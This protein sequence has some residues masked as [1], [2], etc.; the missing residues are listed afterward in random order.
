M[1]DA[2]PVAASIAAYS[3]DPEGYERAYAERS[4]DIVDR[5]SSL[6]PGGSTIL[7][8]GCGPGRDL[9]RFAALGHDVTGLELNPDFVAMAARWGSVVEGDARAVASF[10]QPRSFDGIHANAALVHLTDQ[11]VADVLRQVAQLLVPG[12]RLFL[13]LRSIGSTGWL[14]EPDGRRW[15]HVW[16]PDLLVTTVEAAGFVVDEHHT[17]GYTEVWATLAPHG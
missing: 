1:R 2:D 11:E 7:D 8:L 14:D 9:R 5:F 15:Y 10:F 6:L 4:A 3:N 12:G 16:D 13:S 17:A